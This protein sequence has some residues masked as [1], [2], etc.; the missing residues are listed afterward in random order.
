[1][2][3]LAILVQS[4]VVI[5]RSSS[6]IDIVATLMEAFSMF[7]NLLHPFQ[8]LVTTAVHA[9]RKRIATWTKPTPNPLVFGGVQDFARSKPQLIIENAL[10]RQQLIVL[11]RSTKRPH[12]TTTDRC[13]LVMLA[14]NV[15][16]WKEALLIVKPD[17]VLRWHRQGFRLFWKRKSQAKSREPKVPAE[18]I[19]LIREMAANNRLW[20]AERIR[21]E[22][23][24]PGA[25]VGIKVTKRTIQRYIHQ[26]VRC[27]KCI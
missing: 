3:P 4:V 12:F 14:S 10:L 2:F 7:A 20:G 1:M 24:A 8:D 27:G 9:I 23:G 26:P 25:K 5:H 11:R 22:P 16:A 21:G 17:T 6:L 18:T 15:R 13:L 19:A